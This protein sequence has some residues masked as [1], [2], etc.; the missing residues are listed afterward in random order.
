MTIKPR[1]H[2]A[3]AMRTRKAGA[4]VKT[5]KAIRRK[6]KVELMKY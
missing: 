4:H 3:L 2:V 6:E 5:N 1:N